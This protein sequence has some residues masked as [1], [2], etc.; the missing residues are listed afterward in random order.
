MLNP[1]A[2]L[3]P[4][5]TMSLRILRGCINPSIVPPCHRPMSQLTGHSRLRPAMRRRVSVLAWRS[6][7]LVLARRRLP[8]ISPL[9]HLLPRTLLTRRARSHLRCLLTPLD[10]LS[11][12]QRKSLVDPIRP[13]PRLPCV[14]GQSATICLTRHWTPYPLLPKL[15]AIPDQLLIACPLHR[16]RKLLVSI[17]TPFSNVAALSKQCRHVH[18]VTNRP[19]FLAQVVHLS[20]TSQTKPNT[21][22]NSRL[23]RMPSP[24]R[25]PPPKLSASSILL[26]C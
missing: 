19:F 23:P 11:G 17:L 12:Q 15:A 18:C 5:Q 13:W 20:V 24:K 8:Y 6:L 2:P 26:S 14:M 25:N 4:L 22:R 16:K 3:R 7:P 21:K 9:L 10:P 1:S